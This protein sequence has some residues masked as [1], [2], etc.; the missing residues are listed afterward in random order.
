MLNSKLKLTIRTG[1]KYDA[2]KTEHWQ[3][4]GTSIQDK[5]RVAAVVP[6]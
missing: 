5:Q 4:G 1:R 2:G 6:K 3:L